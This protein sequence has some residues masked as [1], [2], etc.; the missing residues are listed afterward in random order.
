MTAEELLAEAAKCIRCKQVHQPRIVP[1]HP[2]RGDKATTTAA[3]DGHPYSPLLG[4]RTIAR[5]RELIPAELPSC[6]DQV[7]LISAPPE[8]GLLVPDDRG[9]PGTASGTPRQRTR[10]RKPAS[11]A[12]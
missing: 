10:T 8:P 5:L 3:P 4:E 12:G 1:A 2:V 9:R 11:A 7:A 6:A